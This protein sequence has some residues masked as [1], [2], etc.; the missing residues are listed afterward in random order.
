VVVEIDDRIEDGLL[1]AMVCHASATFNL[2]NRRALFGELIR[3]GIDMLIECRRATGKNRI[4][5]AGEKHV[6]LHALD[7]P[8][9]VIPLEL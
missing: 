1:W 2:N 3:G 8:L 7:H 9:V 6:G 5:R 4:M